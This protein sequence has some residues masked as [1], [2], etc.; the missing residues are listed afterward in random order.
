MS[1]PSNSENDVSDSEVESI[2]G[3]IYSSLHLMPEEFLAKLDPFRYNFAY[4]KNKCYK[5]FFMQKCNYF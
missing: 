1:N 3:G 2:E 4:D 5:Y